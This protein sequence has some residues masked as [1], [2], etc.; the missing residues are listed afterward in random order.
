MKIR[1]SRS[2]HETKVD[3]LDVFAEGVNQGTNGN[4]PPFGAP[5]PVPPVTDTQF[6]ALI[7]TYVNARAAYRNGGSAQKTAFDNA[8]EALMEALD[9]TADYVDDIADGD[10]GTIVLAGFVATKGTQSEGHAPAQTAGAIITRGGAGELF[11]EVPKVD[12]AVYYGCIVIA[13]G[14]MPASVTLN[15]SGQLVATAQNNPN[16][17]P[18]PDPTP[19]PAPGSIIAMVDVTKSRKKRFLGLHTGTVY[20]FYFYAANANGVSILSEVRSLSCG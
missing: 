8:W 12:G 17:N 5:N 3:E 4:N 6:L 10:S 18:N 11:A 16:P 19:E 7:A 15:A 2:Y 1:V 14:P 13:G 9:S 20:Y